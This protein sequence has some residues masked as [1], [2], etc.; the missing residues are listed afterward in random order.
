MSPRQKTG[1]IAGCALCSWA[2]LIGIGL[3]IGMALTDLGWVL[4]W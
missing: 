2:T 1:V 3:L 4:Q